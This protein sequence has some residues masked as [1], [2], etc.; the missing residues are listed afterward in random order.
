MIISDIHIVGVFSIAKLKVCVR[1]LT[2]IK[3]FDGN[4]RGQQ[5]L[6]GMVISAGTASDMARQQRL[7]QYIMSNR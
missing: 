6:S 5:C 1:W 2:D 7:I 3:I 4:T